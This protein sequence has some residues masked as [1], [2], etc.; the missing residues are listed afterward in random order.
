MSILYSSKLAETIR[1]SPTPNPEILRV[2]PEELQKARA[3]AKKN[4]DSL[5]GE[6][7]AKV[8]SSAS[9]ASPSTNDPDIIT[10]ETSQNIKAFGELTA[11][12]DLAKSDGTSE[13]LN[14]CNDP[15]CKS[16]PPVISSL[17]GNRRT[18]R[19]KQQRK[20]PSSSKRAVASTT[21]SK[22]RVVELAVFTDEKLYKT[23]QSRFPKDT[24]AKMNQYVLAVVNNVCCIMSLLVHKLLLMLTV[25]IKNIADEHT[26]PATYND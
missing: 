4:Q 9:P 17:S 19:R 11:L 18:P 12:P 1:L 3:E 7:L 15:P 26:V 16:L 23:W 24:T 14:D 5:D 20:G 13:S 25:S 10:N 2:P 22:I 8:N 6:A 21:P